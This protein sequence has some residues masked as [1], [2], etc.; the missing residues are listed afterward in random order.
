[1]R[2]HPIIEL[3]KRHLPLRRDCCK[4][5]REAFVDKISRYQ[6]DDQD[7]KVMT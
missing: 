1:M 4:L 6:S 3:P 2:A 5:N 7:I